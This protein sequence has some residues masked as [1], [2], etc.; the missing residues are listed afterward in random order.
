MNKFNR[1]VKAI[2]AGLFLAIYASTPVIADDI[3][4]YTSLGSS[5]VSI[6]PNILFILDTSGSMDENVYLAKEDYDPNKTYNGCY[7]SGYIYYS[8]N[9]AI[10]SCWIA[11]AF[12]DTALQCDNALYE[13]DSNGSRTGAA[14][15]LQTAGFYTD[16]IAQ[17]RSNNVWNTIRIWYYSDLARPI[18]CKK[19]QGVHGSNS[20]PTP[21]TYITNTTNGWRSSPTNPYVW[22][23]GGSVYTLYHWN[24]LNYLSDPSVFT[25]STRFEEM[26]KAILA[27][28]DAST[29]INI[30]LMRYD[31]YRAEG[32]PVIFPMEDVVTG[33][34]G[35]QAA[36][37]SM[38][39][40]GATP[41]AE[42]YFEALNYFGGREV[43]YGNS[44]SP[45]SVSDSKV[46][47]SKYKSPI[48]DACQKHNIIYLTDGAPTYDH[49]STAQVNSLAG[50][51]NA[52]KF[53][54]DNGGTYSSYSDPDTSCLE[55]MAGWANNYDV[56]Y[57]SS[58]PNHEGEQNITTY[59]IGFDFSSGTTSEQEAEALLR[60][61]AQAGGGRFYEANDAL[62]LVSVFNDIVA[63]I[64]AVNTTFSSPAV[65]VNAFNRAT[66]LDDLY[67]TLFKPSA[68]AHWDGNL[69]KFKIVFDSNGD[70]FIADANGNDAVDPDTGFFSDA[71]TS[72]WTDPSITDGGEVTQGGA[73]GELTPTRNVYTYTG[74][75][76]GSNGISTP[77]NGDL[78]ASANALDKANTAI[79]DAMLGIVG[80][81]P[82][83]GSIPYR[84]TLL[85]W[86][87]GLDVFDQDKDGSTTDAHQIMG[88][89]LHSEPALVQY[90]EV[91]GV[92][93]LAAYVATNDG[94]LHAFDTR[95]GKEIF[96]FVPQELLDLLDINL[97]NDGTL[98]KSY[99]LDGNVVAWVNDTDKDGEI[100]SSD[101]DSVY[102]YIGMRRGG[103]NIYSLDVTDPE[104]PSLR[105]VITGGIGDYAELSQTWSSV[106]VETMQING[107]DR[108]VL[109]FAGGYDPNQDAVSVRT[110]DS[111]G[112]AIFIADA[113]TGERLWWAGP[114]GSGADRELADMQYSIPARIKPLDVNGDGYVDR[115]YTG[116]MGGQLWRVDI[117]DDDLSNITIGRI[118]DLAADADDTQTRRFYYPPDVSLIY[119]E[120][121]APYLAIV[122]ASGYRAHPLNT[123]VYD[124]MYMIRDTDIYKAP[125]SYTTVTEAD[126]Y[127]TTE[128]VIGEG[129]EAQISSATSAL[130]AAKGWYIT[131]NETD[132]SYIG[133][134]SLA[135][136][137]ILNGVAIVT[138]YIPEDLVGTGK[139][140]CLPREGTGRVYYVNI[141]DGTPTYNNDGS[142]DLTRPDRAT[143]L[144]RGGIPPSP[145]VII[146]KDGSGDC[147]GV[148]CRKSLELDNIE[149]TYWYEQ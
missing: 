39:P 81:P 45:A 110:P 116:D 57:D 62:S 119:E 52:N 105:W 122:A 46:S 87:Y 143:Y 85:D 14:G 82:A 77:T 58:N 106:N 42:T 84:D 66:N 97:E 8:S 69:K 35:F 65:S 47:N 147:I 136:P 68:G 148:E 10:P 140:S 15:P 113:E 72:F 40:N 101:G 59:T 137:L 36:V 5:A 34:A 55:Y 37:N 125:A 117:P 108:T 63:E 2:L 73:A 16:Q 88:D 32:G 127:D 83:I 109:I 48:A 129:T 74:S 56:A 115:L 23:S 135:E 12:Y 7:S 78:T 120:G 141:T 145:N 79:T 60:R 96:S 13:Y 71:A 17:K 1:A 124:R 114:T 91:A 144:E 31:S 53:C 30:G 25:T 22:S 50:F 134:K 111:V 18:E 19:D 132:G 41:L 67:F 28:T 142:I 149:K 43:Y 76:V 70:P 75:Y 138:T 24:Y 49:L 61:T 95:N 3:E 20:A 98:G 33:R 94:Y 11:N 89:P 51:P 102:L 86:A 26:K 80:K 107:S 27:L 121:A 9:G 29:N 44:S 4:I 104:N 128:N 92:P 64:L 139:N 130:N 6:K 90:D 93:V 118:A 21:N 126:L 38:S 146:T 131:F 133:E 112:R 103:N 54:A 99:G 100:D 123:D